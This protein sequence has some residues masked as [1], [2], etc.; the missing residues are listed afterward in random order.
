MVNIWCKLAIKRR[1]SKGVFAFKSKVMGIL[2]WILKEKCE[3]IR[4]HQKK[5]SAKQRWTN[6][7]ISSK[8]QCSFMLEC[9]ALGNSL[10]IQKMQFRFMHR[11]PKKT[12]KDLSRIPLNA[13][14]FPMATGRHRSPISGNKPMKNSK[15]GT[16]PRE[17]KTLRMTKL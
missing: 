17:V 12:R 2:K 13:G 3:K 15:A 9:R 10:L 5:Y 4:R 14:P 16:N 1:C 6:S 11:V 8:K 7:V